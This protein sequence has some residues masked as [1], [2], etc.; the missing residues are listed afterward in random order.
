M[1]ST[2]QASAFDLG[3]LTG[4]R[5][6]TP[7]AVLC[8]GSRLGWFRF[9]GTP[10]AMMDRPAALT[11]AS[12]LAAGELVGD[13]L[14]NT[15]ARTDA[16]PLIG[17]MALGATAGAALQ[18]ASGRAAADSAETSAE[19]NGPVS[20]DRAFLAQLI[21]V[22]LSGAAGALVGAFG[23]FY[24]RRGLTKQINVP[25]L[26]VALLEDAL[27]VAGALRIASRFQT[28]EEPIHG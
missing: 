7:L 9:Q 5:S 12:L 3:F 23:T 28:A 8:W 18:F 21:P 24:A 20:L 2:L 27:I 14:P 6:F 26:P 11:V 19:N 1:P 22:L 15:P 4:A 25:D 13:K 10:F 17:R 16:L